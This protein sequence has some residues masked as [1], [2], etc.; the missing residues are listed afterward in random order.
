MAACPTLAERIPGLADVGI[1]AALAV[2][3]AAP[4]VSHTTAATAVTA[5]TR[6]T[7]AV[8]APAVADLAANTD[9]AGQSTSPAEL[10]DASRDAAVAVAAADAILRTA[11]WI[12]R[13]EKAARNEPK[14][15]CSND[16]DANQHHLSLPEL[17]GYCCTVKYTRKFDR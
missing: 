7:G 5:P 9:V 8:R 6:P 2:H 16:T 10:H 15:R 14:D 13:L 1:A 4:L 12:R 3:R 11:H 17:G